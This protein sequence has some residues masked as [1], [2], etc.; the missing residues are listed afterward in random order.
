[1]CL[2]D[3]EGVI[4]IRR[5]NLDLMLRIAPTLELLPCPPQGKRM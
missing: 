5:R 2:T 1:M 3:V 4:V